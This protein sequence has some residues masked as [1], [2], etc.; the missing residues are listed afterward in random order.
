MKETLLKQAEEIIKGARNE[1][2]GPM[3]KSFDR[4]AML[5]SVILN[6]NV[7]SEQV[8]LCMVALKLSRE[9][10]RHLDDNLVDMMGY[11]EI[12][13]QIREDDKD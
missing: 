5:W 9:I 8:C 2:Y 3:R 7:T 1:S 10:H 11:L 12:I 6:K 13:N 4:T